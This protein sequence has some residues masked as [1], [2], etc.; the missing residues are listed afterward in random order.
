MVSVLVPTYRRPGGLA[1]AV[2]SVLEQQLPP[3]SLIE[4]LVCVSDPAVGADMAAAAALAAADSRVRVVPAERPGPA[5]ARN[6]GIAAARGEVIA[7]I[8]DDCRARPGWLAT[9][10]EALRS[11]DLVQGRTTPMGNHVGRHDHTLWV[12][13]PSWLWETC[14]I[15]ARREII[16]RYGGFDDTVYPTGNPRDHFGE[17]VEW[18]WRMVR[19]GARAAFVSASVV[20]HEVTRRGRA[21]HLRYKARARYL[22]WL[23]RVAPES[24]RHFPGRYFLS[25]RHA[26]V[27][28]SAA[29]VGAGAVARSRRQRALGAALTAAGT[30]TY[31]SPARDI[32]IPWVESV[33]KLTLIEAVE[34]G[35]SVYGSLR[36]R[37]LLV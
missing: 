24:R 35:A 30:A 1:T 9:A 8:D 34:L 12:D 18:G 19:S 21:G 26:A 28:A 20:E 37:R 11:A 29:L 25:R 22:P 31:L 17:D 23:F 2:R 10:L 15:V 27:V 13:P 14:N 5:A 33:L 36:W 16:D 7:F 4:V 32:A 6:A 3:G